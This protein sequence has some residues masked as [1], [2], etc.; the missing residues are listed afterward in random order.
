MYVSINKEKLQVK[1]VVLKIVCNRC[2]QSAIYK[3]KVQIPQP[4]QLRNLRCAFIFYFET[5]RKL[6]CGLLFLKFVAD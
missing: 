2:G 5:L 1:T 4:P 3:Y 6:R